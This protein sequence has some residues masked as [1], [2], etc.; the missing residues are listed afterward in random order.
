MVPT[1]RL[2]ENIFLVFFL[3]KKRT[4][5]YGKAGLSPFYHK[6]VT[7]SFLLARSTTTTTFWASLSCSSVS[8][9]IVDICTA[10]NFFSLPEFLAATASQFNFLTNYLKSIVPIVRFLHQTKRSV[11]NFLGKFE[12]NNQKKESNLD[13]RNSTISVITFSGVYI[14][15]KI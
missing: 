5:E 14:S 7:Q 2:C 8:L 15:A 6:I 9:D 10:S 4:W 13:Q 1:D 11:V 12:F 3:A